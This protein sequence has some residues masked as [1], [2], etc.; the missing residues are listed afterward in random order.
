VDRTADISVMR[1]IIPVVAV[2]VCM[3]SSAL[4]QVVQP[5]TGY[6]LP[7]ESD[8]TGDW[9][10]NR[11]TNPMPFHAIGDYNGDGVQDQAWLLLAT[12]GKGFAVFAFIGSRTGS[13]KVVQLTSSADKA[14]DSYYIE[15]V[16]PGRFETACGKEYGD[17]ACEHGEP[18]E[19]NL[20]RPSILFCRFESA[21]SIFWW[22]TRTNTFQRTLISD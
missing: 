14:W 20:T 22:D 5:P 12:S 13:S 19:L 1:I 21:C 15:T 11:A 6:R 17:F 10:D 18:H 9:K 3:S 4:A 8:F 2:A 16:K 7:T